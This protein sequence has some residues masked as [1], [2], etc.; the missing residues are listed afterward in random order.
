[1]DG[2]QLRE[3]FFQLRERIA[4]WS[5]SRGEVL[6]EVFGLIRPELVR[7]AYPR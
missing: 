2:T 5:G 6:A 3:R 4:T 1:M 7:S